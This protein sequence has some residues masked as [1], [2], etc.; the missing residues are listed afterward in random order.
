M[1]YIVTYKKGRKNT[2]V[3]ESPTRR[4]VFKRKSDASRVSRFYKGKVK[5]VSKTGY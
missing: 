2:S 1:G 5:K 4:R 3:L